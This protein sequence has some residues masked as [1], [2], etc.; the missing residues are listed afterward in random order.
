MILR[1]LHESS[2]YGCTSRSDVVSLMKNILM[3]PRYLMMR[4]PG[5]KE[6]GVIFTTVTELPPNERVERSERERPS[7]SGLER[8]RDE[9]AVSERAGRGPKEG[10]NK[11]QRRKK[12]RQQGMEIP[13]KTLN[14]GK[15]KS[16][17]EL[18]GRKKCECGMSVQKCNPVSLCTAGVT[19]VN[20]CT[21]ERVSCLCV[22]YMCD[23]T[24]SGVDVWCRDNHV[25]S[26]RCHAH[27][28]VEANKTGQLHSVC[29]QT[30]TP[31]HSCVCFRV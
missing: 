29:R 6:S 14:S 27:H 8:S 7:G 19:L 2:L 26:V 15:I 16:R 28:A 1:R 3:I 24:C 31:G 21:C 25:E 17:Y 10:E 11:S 12:K 9:T 13:E 5:R 30:D 18:K 4:V 22:R 20:T 23:S